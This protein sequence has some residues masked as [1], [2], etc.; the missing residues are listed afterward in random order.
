MVGGHE[1]GGPLMSKHRVLIASFAIL[2]FTFS[3]IAVAQP[4][5]GA[6]HH[7]EQIV[8]SG[9]GFGTF[10][11]APTPFGFWI[12]CQDADSST[13]YAGECN[14]AMYFYGLGV[15]R[16]VEGEVIETSEGIYQM[17]VASRR[18]GSVSCQLTN[19]E[20]ELNSGPN[21]TVDV[22]CTTPSGS[23]QSTN[24]VVNVTGPEEEE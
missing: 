21:N 6:D 11:D 16:G 18:D 4:G 19:A 24:A 7:S 9:T 1:E 8:F 17:T 2:V 15:T 22:N 5:Q 23:G 14:G 20:E 12:W 3:G 10:N 13:P